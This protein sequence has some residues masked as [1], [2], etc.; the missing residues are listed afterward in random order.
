LDTGANLT[1]SG[2]RMRY[3]FAGKEPGLGVVMG[4]CHSLMKEAWVKIERSGAG[5]VALLEGKGAEGLE[6][7]FELALKE[8]RLRSELLKKSGKFREAV[9]T[10]AL[11]VSPEAGEAEQ[12]ESVDALPDLEELKALDD[13]DF[14][15]DPLDIAV[16]WEE[17]YGK[18]EEEPK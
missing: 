1:V 17:K 16:P 6:D 10:Q 9:I 12:V 14:V 4:V 15:D 8:E 13:G 11:L 7:K 18:K 5:Y 3:E 2:N